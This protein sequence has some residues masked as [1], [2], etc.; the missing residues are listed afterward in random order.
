MKKNVN[1]TCKYLRL[2]ARLLQHVCIAQVGFEW[3]GS[4]GLVG[5]DT[6]RRACAPAGVAGAEIA[7]LAIDQAHEMHFAKVENVVLLLAD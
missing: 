7:I 3:L 1:K 5:G 4:D 6:D 2:N